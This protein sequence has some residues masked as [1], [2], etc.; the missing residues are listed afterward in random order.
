VLRQIWRFSGGVLPGCRAG[1]RL[2]TGVVLVADAGSS[3]GYMLL[4]CCSF[5]SDGESP[6]LL[7][8]SVLSG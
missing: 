2:L 4:A 7:P 1:G 6:G 5:G 3:R 8:K